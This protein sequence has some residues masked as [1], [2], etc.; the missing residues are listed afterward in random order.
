MDTNTLLKYS[1]IFLIKIAQKR[2]AAGILLICAEDNTCFLARRSPFV[3]KPS[4]WA[5]PGGGIESGE[6]PWQA[7]LREFKEEIGQLPKISKPSDVKIYEDESIKFITFIC[8]ISLNEKKSFKPKLN[9]END[10]AQWF[11]PKEIPELETLES[12]N[13]L[14]EGIREL[15]Y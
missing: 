11:S 12:F 9:W 3:S 15:S 8:N 5:A 7:A 1:N 4:L 14:I 10:A 13:K 2:E 6:N